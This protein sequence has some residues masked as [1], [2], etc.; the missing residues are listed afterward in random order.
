MT[1]SMRV[2]SAGDGYRYLLRSVVIGDADHRISSPLTRY[3]V[4]E[5]TPIG[6]CTEDR[7]QD[8]LGDVVEREEHPEPAQRQPERLVLRPH[9]RRDPVG[10]ERS[11]EPRRVQRPQPWGRCGR[12]AFGAHI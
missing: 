8:Q 1:V 5:G 6:Q 4:G 12:R 7:F 2:M 9:G 11:H 3:F 10:T